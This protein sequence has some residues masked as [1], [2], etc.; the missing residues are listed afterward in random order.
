MRYIQ[1]ID[2]VDCIDPRYGKSLGCSEIIVNT[3]PNRKA[4][5][6]YLA[7]MNDDNMIVYNEQALGI[8]DCS[9]TW[10]FMMNPVYQIGYATEVFLD[11]EKPFFDSYDVYER[12]FLACSF[13][14]VFNYRFNDFFAAFI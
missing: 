10:H 1:N 8:A 7:A 3:S 2:F 14:H 13:F 9:V 4:I 6:N 12:L 5:H 11:G